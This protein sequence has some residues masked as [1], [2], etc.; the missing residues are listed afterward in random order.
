MAYCPAGRPLV[1]RVARS[2]N[3]ALILIF[4]FIFIP[5]TARGQTSPGEKPLI[6]VGGDFNYPPYEFLD[7]R[8]EPAGYNVDLTKAIAETMGFEVRFRLGP[9][10]EIRHDLETGKIDAVHGMFYSR[11]RSAIFDFSPPH[12]TIYH[13]LF[14]RSDAPPVKNLDEVRNREIL[15]MKG[16][17]MHDFALA[18]LA[19]S[20][21]I[22][23]VETQAEALRLLASGKHDFALVAKLPGLYWIREFKLSNLSAVGPPINPAEYSYAVRKGNTQLLARFSEGLAILNQTGRYREIYDKW[24]GILEP[25]K[26]S[27]R[28][29][30][31]AM[32]VILVPLLI[33]L[34]GSAFWSYSLRR[35]VV[36]KTQSLQDEIAIRK[37]MEEEVRRARDALDLRVRERTA[38]LM[39]TNQALGLSEEHLRLTFDQAPIGAAMVGLDF[40]FIR[41]NAALGRITGYSPEDLVKLSFVDITHPDDI[42]ADVEQAR[43]LADGQIDHYR[44]DKRYIRK[45]GSIVWIHISVSLVRDAQ[46][47]PLY[48]LPMIE[49][50]SERR[51]AVEELKAYA[52]RLELMNNELQEF[53]FVASHDLQEP[54]RK[55][56]AFSDLLMER[57]EASLGKEDADYLH[58]IQKGARQMS[59]HLRALLSYSRV[60]TQENAPSL[61][62]LASVARR[63]TDNLAT[64]IREANAQVDIGGMPVLEVN[65]EQM[66]ELF[67]ILVG[68]ALKYRRETEPLLV[69]IHGHCE[70]GFCR[71]FVEDNGIGFDEKYLDRIFKPFQRLHGRNSQYDGTGIGLAICRKIAER[72]GG[73]ITARSRRGEGSTFIVSLPERSVG[74]HRWNL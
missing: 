8:G 45:D 25:P 22:I 56:Q 52:V 38:E 23:P 48:Y 51:R 7:E 3:V 61:T 41:V 70:E 71:I 42:E 55:I 46:G 6:T 67:K 72:H 13:A 30:A 14:A 5:T 66:C 59:S 31:K 18:H 12:T 64:A 26:F 15:V 68:N 57:C 44:M 27:A 19:P 37:Q 2:L 16:D 74:K 10:S 43:Q 63:V 36:E 33:L 24:L 1:E 53:I 28:S 62:D 20:N 17:I 40:R 32:A 4:L 35:K 29:I 69:R 49:D 60:A 58:R 47:T 50:I 34:L 54:L 65:T 9:W 73:S 11:E 39:A 21:T